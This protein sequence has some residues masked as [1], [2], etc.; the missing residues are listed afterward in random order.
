MKILEKGKLF[1]CLN[2]FDVVIVLLILGAVGGLFAKTATLKKVMKDYTVSRVRTV[3]L[4]NNVYPEQAEAVRPGAVV[5]ELRSGEALGVVKD[6]RVKDYME[7]ASDAQGN[8]HWSPVPGKKD[9]FIT[10]EGDLKSYNGILR[11]GQVNVAAGCKINITSP[12]F[13]FEAQVL[14][15]DVLQ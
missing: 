10:V 14:K 7:K 6:V 13:G 2:I 8:W 12:G 1:G 5:S 11:V 15:V 9:V 4:V 3:L